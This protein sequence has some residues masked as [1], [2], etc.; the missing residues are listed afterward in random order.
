MIAI[1]DAIPGDYDT[2][3]R[4]FGELGVEDLIPT[5]ETF[6]IE[7]VPRIL[8]ATRDSTVTG[9]LLWELLESTGYVRNIVADPAHRRR[10]IGAALM[11]AARERFA[12]ATDWCL[13]VKVENAAAI[14]LYERCGM[15]VRHTTVVMR[16]AADI[17]LPPPTAGLTVAHLPPDRDAEIEPLFDL[18]PGQLASAR[19]KTGR[20]VVALSRGNAVLGIA[21]MMSIGA[22]P[23]R[24]L[25]A[26]HA[27]TFMALLRPM[28]ALDAPWLQFSADNDEARVE[29]TRLGCTTRMELF[30]M[31]GSL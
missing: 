12:G 22:F 11:A 8:V 16:L 25:D 29:L 6:A 15:R 18:L 17:V 3:V 14:A 1:R 9:Y 5:A 7:L 13:N 10:G 31:R 19:K 30:H 26:S 27:G 4:L 23:F 20:V 2:Y 24:V 21:V 28:G